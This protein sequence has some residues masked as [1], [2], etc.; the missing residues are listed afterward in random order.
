MCIWKHI[1][2]NWANKGKKERHTLYGYTNTLGIHMW[3]LSMWSQQI[4]N[5]GR[6]KR[7][8]MRVSVCIHVCMRR[9]LFTSVIVLVFC[10]AVLMLC[11]AVYKFSNSQREHAHSFLNRIAFAQY[12]FVSS[13]INSANACSSRNC[14]FTYLSLSFCRWIFFSS[15]IFEFI[16]NKQ[17]NVIFFYNFVHCKNLKFIKFRVGIKC[18]L[19]FKIERKIFRSNEMECLKNIK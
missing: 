19:K 14:F 9:R 1:L 11:S 18:K 5:I 6:L 3:L 7:N 8:S 12:P 2:Y 13:R 16:V 15:I 17:F 4:V 10:C